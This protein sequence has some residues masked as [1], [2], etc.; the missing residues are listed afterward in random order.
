MIAVP[1]RDVLVAFGLSG[2]AVPMHGGQ[3]TS[4][5]VGNAV[6]K[7][8]DGDAELVDG[9]AKIMAAVAEDGFRVARPLRT[10][11][12]RWSHDGWTASLHVEGADPGRRWLEI[13]AAGRAFHAALAGFPRPA[14]LDRRTDAWAVG[15]RAA[16]DEL[17]VEVVPELRAVH[18][19]LSR[20][21][22]SA[23]G[24]GA[25]LVHGDLTGNVLL[26]PGLPPAVIDFSPYWRP[27]AFAE[28]I[29]IG[30]AVLWH[31][32]GPELLAELPAGVVARA[33]V[34]RLVTTSERVRRTGRAPTAAEIA[35]Y[36]RAARLVLAC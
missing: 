2:T 33:L 36:E 32:A 3:G 24:D 5:R 25:Q 23:T 15:D 12:G 21:A 14:F 29:V 17:D 9:P 18:G 34:Y 19:E 4:V 26:A 8:A 10:T 11:D 13:I 7:P 30:D 22:P 35:E 31:G 27:P 6:L 16:W 1:T 20:L 28:A